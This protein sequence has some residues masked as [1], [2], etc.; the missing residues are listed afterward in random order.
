MFGRLVNR[1]RYGCFISTKYNLTTNELNKFYKTK[2]YVWMGTYL[3]TTT[4]Y[5]N[6][7]SNNSNYTYKYL[8]HFYI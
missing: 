2:V 5:N 3:T 8:L 7:Y 6:V 1:C 4:K